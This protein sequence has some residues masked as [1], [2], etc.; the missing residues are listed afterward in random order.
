MKRIKADEKYN[1]P[2]LIW[3]T[4]ISIR[5]CINVFFNLS[6]INKYRYMNV[7]ITNPSKS[8]SRFEETVSH[9]GMK[10]EIR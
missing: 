2:I 5:D 8:K 1:M 3:I 4:I 9:T 10:N 6:E 7:N